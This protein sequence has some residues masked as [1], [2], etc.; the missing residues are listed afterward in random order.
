MKVTI[1]AITGLGSIMCKGGPL[2]V[3]IK[4]I[5]NAWLCKQQIKN[6]SKIS[7]TIEY[8]TFQDLSR[9]MNITSIFKPMCSE[10]D[11]KSTSTAVG[12]YF[13]LCI[14]VKAD[15]RKLGISILFEILK[16]C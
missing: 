4:Y 13:C 2:A 5:N 3:T 9:E 1:Q 16:N 10:S 6:L 7:N 14:F 11:M 15:Q 8:I 12:K